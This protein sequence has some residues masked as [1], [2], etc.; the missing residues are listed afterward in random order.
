[1]GS[2]KTLEVKLRYAKK[3]KQNRPMPFWVRYK[4]GNT[5]RYNPKRRNWRRK[6][7][8]F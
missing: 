6:K 4:T 3:I 8:G 7:L 5:I 2:N 1:M